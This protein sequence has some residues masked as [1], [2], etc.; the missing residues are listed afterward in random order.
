MK[1]KIRLQG[2]LLIALAIVLCL[3]G[4]TVGVM[5]LTSSG[6][7]V[8]VENFVGKDKKVVETWRKKNDVSKDQIAYAYA[9][10]DTKDKDIVLKQ[11]IASGKTLKSDET[12]KV[13]VS[14]GADPNKEFELPDFTD[15]EEKEIKKW[16][17]DNKFTNVTY[18]YEIN[19]EVENGK[20]ISMDHETGTKVKRSEPITVTICTPLD[21]EQVEVPDLTGISKADLDSWASTNRINISYIER[22]SDTVEKGGI[23]SVSVNK[24]DRLN[25]GDTITVEI[26]SGPAENEEDREKADYKP[27]DNGTVEAPSNVSGGEQSGGTIDNSNNGGSGDNT[28]SDAGEETTVSVNFVYDQR[29]VLALQGSFTLDQI[30][31]AVINMARQSGVPNPEAIKFIPGS[32][33]N[34]GVESLTASGTPVSSGADITCTYNISN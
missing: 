15:K 26:S 32:G 6:S 10:D 5:A 14:K 24:G 22:A 9:Y 12:L 33:E 11:S 25:A 3:T 19:P 21:A 23:L 7:G 16:F 8:T 31:S 29:Q 17:T 30:K 18:T 1:R 13:T 2:K 27:A 28:P 34:P 20:F 4:T